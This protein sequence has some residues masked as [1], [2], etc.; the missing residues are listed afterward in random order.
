MKKIFAILTAIIVSSALYAQNENDA[1]RYSLINYGG[2][3]R[4]A[5]MSGAYGAVGADFSSL[6]QNPAGIAL[7]RKSEFTITPVLS[8]NNT[9]S[10]YLGTSVSD[11]RTTMYLGNVGYVFSQNLK[12]QAGPLVNIQ[13]GF[14]VNQLA[15]FN[16]R[17]TLSG[18][19]DGD[20]GNSLLT[21][22]VQDVNAGND[23]DDFG[24]GL[25]YDVNLIYYDSTNMR[26]AADMEYGGIQQTKSVETQGSMN[27]TVLSAGANIADK[28][29]LGITF[30]FPFIRYEEYSVY[31]ENDTK[32]LNSYF[33]SFQRNE[34][35]YTRGTGFNFKAGFI[36]MPV[37]FIRIGGAIHTP[38][39]FYN[40][41]DSYHTTMN[42]YFSGSEDYY[43][44]SPS[45]YFEYELKTP[46]RA[47]G[48]VAVLLG[49]YG[50][51]SADYE[52]ID[53]SDASMQAYDYSFSEENSAIKS[54]YTSSNNL[55]LGAELKAGIM[56]FRGGYSFS[57]SPFRETG[58]T[59][60][61]NGYSFGIGVREKGYFADF[62][63]NHSNTEAN[64]YL[65]GNAPAAYNHL[66]TNAYSLTLGFRF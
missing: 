23:W 44:D 51:I 6:S 41:S 31:T 29:F 19:N 30:A 21:G 49:K 18:F 66:K 65:Y 25:A 15:R 13:F 55:R 27:E 57:E 32:D 22:Y 58:K 62:S 26:W 10:N 43:E 60:E 4:F 9:E 24:S 33:N 61:R 16:N 45:G 28:L 11:S 48:S 50:L 17:M 1:L 36:F 42:S 59:G 38:T 37:E 20:D 12:G 5:G 14:G 46:L 7:Y 34:Y 2:T 63:Y 64:Y 47:M 39:N 53:Y 8:S 3:A 54:Q 35:L 52:Y 56:A 40:M